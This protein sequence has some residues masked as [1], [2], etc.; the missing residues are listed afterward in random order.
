MVM[1]EIQ[2]KPADKHWLSQMVANKTD[3][4]LATM[5]EEV[6]IFRKTGVIPKECQTLRDLAREIQAVTK[7]DNIL[8]LRMAEDA[9]LYEMSRRYYNS[10][11]IEQ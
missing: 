7:A 2:Q 1:K 9:L 10:L 4:Q 6:C 11:Y 3:Q 5:Y 8:E